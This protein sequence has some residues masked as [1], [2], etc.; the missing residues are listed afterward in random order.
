MNHNYL[1]SESGYKIISLKIKVVDLPDKKAALSRL[2]V[3]A[4]RLIHQLDNESDSETSDASVDSNLH[5]QD[6]DETASSNE[7]YGS[8]QPENCPNFEECEQELCECG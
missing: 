3:N 2:V 1:N 4:P 6:S 7:S 8:H 5:L